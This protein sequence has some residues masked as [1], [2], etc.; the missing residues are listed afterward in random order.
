MGTH[1]PFG[2]FDLDLA[3]RPAGTLLGFESPFAGSAGLGGL[4]MTLRCGAG[5]SRELYQWLA[6]VFLR[7]HQRRNGAV[8]KAASFGAGSG[9][10]R[11]LEFHDA[12]VTEV[13]LPALDKSLKMPASMTVK[14]LAE[15]FAETVSSSPARRA[16]KPWFA[17]DFKLRI[18][19]LDAECRQVVAIAAMSAK[20]GI[21]Q[22]NLGS[23]RIDRIHP[24]KTGFSNLVL[25]LPGAGTPGADKA[26]A[27]FN[28][29]FQESVKGISAERRGSLEYLGPG[30][31]RAYFRL[32]FSG[33]GIF[34]MT[35]MG[36]TQVE[37]YCDSVSFSAL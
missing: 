26:V 30:G 21:V 35:T 29:W 24:T 22:H 7:S 31:G 19:G 8:Y 33:L 28:R 13:S 15:H 3:G 23:D 4:D 20:T 9:G 34:K 36:K 1:A 6:A 16:P 17:S 5:M 18:E 27:A 32:D 11:R 2:R 10:A 37:T 12:L 25:T 14:L